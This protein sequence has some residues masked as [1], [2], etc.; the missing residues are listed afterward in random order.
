MT[1]Q[2]IHDGLTIDAFA[3]GSAKLD[4]APSG[5]RFFL[6]YAGNVAEGRYEVVREGQVEVL[7]RVES[8]ELGVLA[9]GRVVKGQVSKTSYVRIA[10]HHRVLWAGRLRRLQ[11]LTE[12]ANQVT[13]GQ[14]CAL[15]FDG[16]D[17]IQPGDSVE[18]FQLVPT[19]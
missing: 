4:N 2:G 18:T 16:F 13:C 17:D 10:R 1:D 8:S 12:Q 7:N 19:H 9:G 3:I 15:G 11:R 6:S 14:E 5:W